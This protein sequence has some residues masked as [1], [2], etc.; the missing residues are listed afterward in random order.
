MAY[1]IRTASPEEWEKKHGRTPKPISNALLNVINAA[2]HDKQYRTTVVP[3]AE[4]TDLKKEL[5][6]AANKLG[7]TCSKQVQSD[8]PGYKKVLFKVTDRVRRPRKESI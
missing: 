8:K 4:V 2:Y 7:Y 3:D 6:R 1:E 5:Q